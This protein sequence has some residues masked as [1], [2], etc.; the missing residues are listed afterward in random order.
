MTSEAQT[1]DPFAEVSTDASRLAGRL[2]R[3]FLIA[4]GVFGAWAM[5]VP[6]DSAV[7]APGT[8]MSE[9]R[10]L[11]LQHVTGGVIKSI[12]AHE[13]DLVRAGEVVLELEPLVDRARLSK[14]KARQAALEAIESRLQA[15]KSLETQSDAG[16][17]ALVLNASASP[18]GIGDLRLRS[19]DELP[20]TASDDPMNEIVRLLQQEQEREFERGRSAVSAQIEALRNRAEGERRRR[21]G[22]VDQA[23]DSARQL[24]LLTRQIENARSL[25]NAGHLPKRELWDLE[26][27]LLQQQSLDAKLASDAAASERAIAEIEA[28][29]ERVRMTD[30][31]ENSQQLTDVLS[32]LGQIRDEIA[33]AEQ[34]LS[35][36]AIVAPESGHLVHFTANTPGG[37]VPPGKTIG[38]IV[39]DEARLVARGRVS[40]QDITAVRVGY[41]TEV[42]VTALHARTEDPILGKV[43]FVAQDSTVDERT[44]ERYFEVEASLD[45]DGREATRNMIQAGMG[46]EMFIKGEPRTF[47]SYLTQPLTDALGRTF[48]EH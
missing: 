15:E 8:L 13:G 28:E 26:S 17:R 10:N 48:R 5:V 23:A 1:I 29:M 33:A 46:V 37:V 3:G 12:R 16:D 38:E 47:A 43:S 25:T 22:L 14:L 24:D 19:A 7:I 34:S 44:G 30:A 40:I 35:Q 9:G 11:V 6:L 42:K 2:G 21:D 27:R 39:P 18:L 41:E 31:K 32:E 4:L 36:T 45:L 20:A